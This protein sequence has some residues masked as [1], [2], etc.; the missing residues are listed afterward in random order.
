[1]SEVKDTN[2][3]DAIGSS[4]VGIS[5]V[6]ARVMM[7]VGLGMLEGS[8]KY[9]RHNYRVAGVRAS[10]YFDATMRHM[11]D[12]WEG[13]DIDPDSGLHHITK[14]IASLVVLRDSMFQ[15]NM[16]DDRPPS[17]QGGWIQEMNEKAKQILAK[18]PNP[19]PAHVRNFHDSVRFSSG[20]IHI[21]D[22]K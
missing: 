4:K 5:N 16:V 19:L 21:E 18:Y 2:P 9:G 14:A 13:T 6:P 12:W 3:K 11:F 15:G 1:M 8:C 20:S 7:E 22:T 10:V 17:V